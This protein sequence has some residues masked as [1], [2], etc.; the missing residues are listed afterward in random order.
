MMY[1][2]IFLLAI[3]FN[4][5]IALSL[6]PSFAVFVV[7]S[8]LIA[9]YFLKFNHRKVKASTSGTVIESHNN[10]LEFRTAL[11]F[12]SLFILFGFLTGIVNKFFGTGGINVLSFAVGVTDIDPFILNLLQSKWNIENQALVM[13]IL[14]AITSNNLLKMIYG[15]TFG[16][17]S[18][19]KQLI[20]GFSILVALGI[21]FSFVIHF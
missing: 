14:N 7:I 17:K 2:R 8:A 18:I 13:A 10:P 16:D 9:L 11:I 4:K 1:L 5:T 3:I 15:L 21:I 12:G 6:A 19:R 20:T